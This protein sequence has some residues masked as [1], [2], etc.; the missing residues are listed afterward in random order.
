MYQLASRSNLISGDSD[1]N[2]YGVHVYLHL[3]RIELLATPHLNSDY[4]TDDAW[5][6]AEEYEQRNAGSA[7][8]IMP[9][10]LG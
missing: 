7:C 8:G 4:Y 9:S 10:S 5:L 1:Q 6:T 2:P 3:Y